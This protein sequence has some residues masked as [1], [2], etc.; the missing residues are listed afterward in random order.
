MISTR[1]F[2]L[3]AR[4]R[5]LTIRFKF[6]IHLVALGWT[7]YFS[8]CFL[9]AVHDVCSAPGTCTT[10]FPQR[11]CTLLVFRP[12]A[13]RVILSLASSSHSES[14]R[15]ILPV[16]RPNSKPSTTLCLNP[17]CVLCVL[18]VLLGF[19]LCVWTVR[20]SYS[21]KVPRSSLTEV[22]R[23]FVHHILE[24]EVDGQKEGQSDKKEDGEEEEKNRVVEER[25]IRHN[26][27]NAHEAWM[28]WNECGP[29]LEPCV[30]M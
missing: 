16:I 9:H 10:V 25:A 26:N 17:V 8:C 5:Y 22:H 11:F 20:G 6:K 7:C 19:G 12:P 18:C 14:S 21:A 28:R 13:Q 24:D 23:E 15:S 29:K 30:C 27:H 2:A 4:V 3:G 1:L